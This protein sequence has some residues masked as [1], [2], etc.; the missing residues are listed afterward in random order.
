MSVNAARRFFVRRISS[1]IYGQ[2]PKM[3]PTLN[4]PATYPL[5]AIV[6]IVG[7]AAT[8]VGFRCL[9][10][11]PDVRLSKARRNQIIRDWTH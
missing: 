9:I 6:S 1:Q 5:V 4:D 3:K 7:L 8:I 2:D 11:N 10:C